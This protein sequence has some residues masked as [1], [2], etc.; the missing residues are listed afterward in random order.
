MKMI[1]TGLVSFFTFQFL[2]PIDAVANAKPDLSKPVVMAVL[3]NSNRENFEAKT[4]PW[5]KG[6]I[7]DCKICE[8]RNL[9][10]YGEKGE[11]D[12]TA[13]AA[14]I[15]PAKSAVSFL[16]VTWNEKANPNNE[17]LIEALK[18]ATTEGLIV[19]GAAGLPK[20][21]EEASAPL[22]KTLLGQIPDA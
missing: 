6:Q 19:V 1:L 13:T 7:A 14:Q 12:W 22:S 5:L 10:A 18:K 16:F 21:A 20:S 2:M 15:D 8:I 11:V 4:L 9:T 17:K 3:D